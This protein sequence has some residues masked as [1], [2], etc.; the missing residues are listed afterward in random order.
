MLDAFKTSVETDQPLDLDKILE[1]AATAARAPFDH[2]AMSS[3]MGQGLYV[4]KDPKTG[5]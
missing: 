5:A 1:A 3:E 4:L 2:I